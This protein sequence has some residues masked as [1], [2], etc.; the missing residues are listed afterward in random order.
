MEPRRP[1]GLS[2]TMPTLRLLTVM[3]SISPINE[4]L[5]KNGRRRVVGGISA[6]KTGVESGKEDKFQGWDNRLSIEEMP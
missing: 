3:E 4:L 5:G 2:S 1:T 6:R